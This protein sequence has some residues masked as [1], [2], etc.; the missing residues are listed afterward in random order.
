MGGGGGGGKT[1]ASP[2]EATNSGNNVEAVAYNGGRNGILA[3]LG[4]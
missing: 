2:S 1:Q 3:G 4:L